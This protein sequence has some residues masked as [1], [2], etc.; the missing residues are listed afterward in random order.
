MRRLVSSTC[1]AEEELRFAIH[2]DSCRRCQDRLGTLAGDLH[3]K[4]ARRDAP[5]D[6]PALSSVIDR[7]QKVRPHTQ[8]QR[9]LEETRRLDARPSY[10]YLAP[11][12]RADSLGRLGKYEVLRVLGQGGM[13]VVFAAFDN[14]LRREVAI[15]VPSAALGAT[16][17][18][19]ERFMR[20]ARAIAAVKHEHIVTMYA[21]ED[22]NDTLFL[23]MELVHG[24]SLAERLRETVAL[25]WEEAAAV[26]SEI[27]EALAEAHARGLVHRDIKPGN[28]LLESV[29]NRVKVTDFGLAKSAVDT[30]L[31]MTG[32]I[33]GTPEYMSPEQAREGDVGPLS[34]LFSLGTVL[35]QT[36]TGQSPFQAKSALASLNRV[37]FDMP[38]PLHEIKP[39]IPRWFSDLIHQL[40]AK[41]SADRPPSARDVQVRLSEG[42]RQ[43]AAPT[44]PSPALP[45]AGRA[46]RWTARALAA[47]AVAV[48]VIGLSLLALQYRAS[49][50]SV[51]GSAEPAFR[52]G[53]VVVPNAE[54]FAT[55]EEAI[56]AAP[57]DGEIEIFGD[58][59][60][61]VEGIDLGAKRLAIR[62]APGFRP[63]FLSSSGAVAASSAFLQ[64]EA[65]LRLQG[66][67]VQWTVPPGRPQSPD[68]PAERC[69]VSTRKGNV[70]LA[71][72]RL[73]AGRLTGCISAMDGSIELENSHFVAP[74]GPCVA[75]MPGDGNE[76]EATQCVFEG[77][78]AGL[79]CSGSASSSAAPPAAIRLVHNSFATKHAIVMMITTPMRR[80]D[81]TSEHNAFDSASLILISPRRR[82][83]AGTGSPAMKRQMMASRL[84]W[85]ESQNAYR[86]GL[87]YMARGLPTE[88][89]PVEVLVNS[90]E[91]WQSL[92]NQEGSG[93]F[94]VQFESQKPN[95][96]GSDPLAAIRVVSVPTPSRTGADLH[97]VGPQIEPTER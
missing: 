85:T 77:S 74:S 78:R 81:C 42:L 37:T 87:N 35:Y 90:L 24:Q 44:G 84:L 2:L 86:S 66:L 34:D 83:S 29:T 31:T 69:I 50:P 6:S 16:Q 49:D 58:G 18:A 92:W 43:S 79:I 82:M 46:G 45:T 51:T 72:C 23:V 88:N 32:M 64:T 89:G 65:D 21:V 63:L 53:F 8:L 56:R 25:A 13:G 1:S 11:S 3:E 28:I 96:S 59:P 12:D 40:L 61:R 30:S 67:E 60:Y 4:V 68:E 7:L 14:S 52:S 36:C 48:A 20:E 41:D 71:N 19:H 33:A 5:A 22:V 97:R 17:D 55:L 26:G 95:P 91:Q 47:G 9:Q 10:S 76:L 38:P 39:E 75:W 54:A 73:T 27:A 70:S 15:K 93:A 94:E 80:F 57:D 62:A